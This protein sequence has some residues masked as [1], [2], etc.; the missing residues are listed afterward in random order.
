MCACTCPSFVYLGVS[1]HYNVPRRP[2]GVVGGVGAL[3]GGG[4]GGL[5]LDAY[6][7]SFPNHEESLD[8]TPAF[9]VNQSQHMMEGKMAKLGGIH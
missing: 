7:V 6:E 1:G 2:V 4:G 8:R 9:H 5:Y 3:G